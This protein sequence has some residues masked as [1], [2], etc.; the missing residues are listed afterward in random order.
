MPPLA[1]FLRT[2]CGPE[3]SKRREIFSCILIHAVSAD[4]PHFN[5][6]IV[7]G[8]MQ[9][10]GKLEWTEV[11]QTV[12]SVNDV[13]KLMWKMFQKISLQS[14]FKLILTSP[15]DYVLFAPIFLPRCI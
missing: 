2:I 6:M 15:T 3:K 1:R 12:R 9:V 5:T 14:S 4:A 10:V 13:L 7:S 11:E 8:D